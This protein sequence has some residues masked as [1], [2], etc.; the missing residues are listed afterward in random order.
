MRRMLG[1]LL[2]AMVAVPA[3]AQSTRARLDE[4]DL[5]VGQLE[6][7]VRGQALVE[8]SQRFDALANEARALRGDLEL[9][10]QENAALREQQR[11]L[12]LAFERQLAA[13]ESRFAALSSAS[14][15]AGRAST[16]TA[17]GGEAGTA[18]SQPPPMT[19]SD[20]A[21]GSASAAPPAA[22]TTSRPESA[23]VLYGR[24]FDHLKAARYPEAIAG[25][26][27]VLARYPAHALADNAQYWIGQAHYVTRDYEKAVEAFAALVAR[28][29]DSAKTPDALLK[30]GLAESELG[31]TDAA[32]GTLGEV[33]RRFPQNDAARLAREQ[34]A[35]LR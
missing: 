27:D 17:E 5:R 19:A 23:E 12:A 31:R 1:M 13:L 7:S 4:L 11:E 32:R 20:A 3:M 10:Q 2:L 30:K 18:A 35:R 6:E 9:L 26:A 24:A 16:A 34:L 33:I 15:A 21:A 14:A 25:M 28:A 22:P 8:L 29:S